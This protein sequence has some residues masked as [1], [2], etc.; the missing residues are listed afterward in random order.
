[1]SGIFIA[2]A[3]DVEV[4]GN[5]VENNASGI[6][7]LQQDRIGDQCGIGVNNEVVNLF[8][9]DN[10]IVQATGRAAG[11]R[12]AISD[13]SYYTSKNNRWEDNTYRLDDL[14]AA[15]FLWQS[16]FIDAAAWRSLGLDQPGAVFDQIT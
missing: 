7:A 9:H 5:T 15:L 3:R 1:M 16:G 2:E 4:Y 8:V 12:V 13:P 10:T 11:L 6:V 14:N